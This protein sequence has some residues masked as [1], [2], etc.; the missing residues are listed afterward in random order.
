MA[1]TRSSAK[2]RKQS[3]SADPARA[4]RLNVIGALIFILLLG[5]GTASSAASKNPLGAI[6]GS[7]LG[8]LLGAAPRIANQWERAVVLRLGKY[9]GLRGPGLF[10]IVPFIDTIAAWID[11]RVITTNFKAEETTE[12]HRFHGCARNEHQR[13]LLLQ[14]LVQDIHRPEVQGRWILLIRNR[15]LAEQRCDLDFGLS[16]N[17]P[18]LF[19]PRRLCLTRHRVLQLLRNHDVAHLH[20]LHGDAPRRRALV[21][22]FLQLGFD[23]LAPTKQICKRG[24]AD[25]VS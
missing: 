25:N 12:A 20:R 8:L 13:A 7:V 19:F 9:R 5:V 2:R 16:E 10:W 11:Q 1:R 18:C 15:G 17:D 3:T 23:A 22:Q 21:D 14:A 4:A 6:A 24:A